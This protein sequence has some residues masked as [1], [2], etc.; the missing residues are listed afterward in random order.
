MVQF[1][2]WLKD[3]RDR[4]SANG[5]DQRELACNPHLMTQYVRTHL[6]KAGAA[7]ASAVASTPSLAMDA[8]E[9]RETWEDGR[10]A[11][12][13]MVIDAIQHLSSVLVAVGCSDKELTLRYEKST[14]EAVLDSESSGTADEV[15]EKEESPESDDSEEETGSLCQDA[16]EDADVEEK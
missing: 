4:I 15:Q 8:D 16:P 3:E 7:L 14:S 11:F 10:E 12:V 2:T 1:G 9:A 13:D 6:L 5:V